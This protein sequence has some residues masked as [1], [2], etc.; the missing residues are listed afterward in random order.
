[1]N[2]KLPSKI[3]SGNESRAQKGKM[4]KWV[5]QTL[6]IDRDWKS[7]GLLGTKKTIYFIQILMIRR[8]ELQT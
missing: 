4:M 8:V 6:A 1:M 7:T 5:F 2:G 3:P